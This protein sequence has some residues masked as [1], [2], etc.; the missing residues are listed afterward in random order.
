V[1]LLWTLIPT[2]QTIFIGLKS[3][4]TQLAIAKRRSRD[5]NLKNLK[6]AQNGLY[7]MRVVPDYVA[8]SSL[9]NI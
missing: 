7:K 6:Y 2:L 8:S 5:I 1:D 3:C 9:Q 4:L